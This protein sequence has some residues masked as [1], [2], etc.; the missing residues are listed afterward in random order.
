MRLV[1][2]HSRTRRNAMSTRIG[3]SASLAMLLA[4]AAGAETPIATDMPEYIVTAK[5]PEPQAAD[6]SGVAPPA[7]VVTQ[8]TLD[9]AVVLEAIRTEQQ[10]AASTILASL[11]AQEPSS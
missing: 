8:T 5:Y 9:T 11:N 3:L 10:K 7:L 6:H 4:V 1:E 2:K